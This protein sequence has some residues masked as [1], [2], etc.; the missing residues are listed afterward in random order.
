MGGGAIGGYLAV[1]LSAGGSPVTL[2]VRREQREPVIV[3]LDGTVV[4]G[5][6]P[7]TI[8]TDRAALA[9]VSACIVAVKSTA[10]REIGDLLA[11]VLP[12]GVPVIAFQNGLDNV[13]ILEKHFGGRAFGGV[14]TFHV[15]AQ[16]HYRRRAS[17]G[18]LFIGGPDEPAIQCVAR[19]LIRA[20]ERVEL[21]DDMA[22]VM[23][24]KLL[25][26]LN[27][28]ICAA[29][30]LGIRDVMESRDCRWALA[31]CV[32]E[33]V[34][35]MHRAGIVPAR[36]SAI[37]PELLATALTLPDFVVA[38][39]AVAVTAMDP[40]ARSSTLAD[41]DRGRRTEIDELNGAIVRIAEQHH[42]DAP[43]NRLVVGI[44]HE[45]EASAVAGRRPAYL[46]PREL[47]ERIERARA[48]ADL[49][50]AAHA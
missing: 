32:R 29:T 19:S 9:A 18:K 15:I 39:V 12:D 44:V 28:G 43:I 26:N 48:A 24:G 33:G 31:H 14:V 23:H 37:S 35:V 5:R 50:G 21:V 42:I 46:S 40:A 7:I 8:T 30:G 34:G 20:G 3:R 10:T 2:H 22:S 36:V 1:A 41:L 25:L 13:G 38:R 4:R 17:K 11:P 47:R 49:S 27:N 16:D 6:A 45:H